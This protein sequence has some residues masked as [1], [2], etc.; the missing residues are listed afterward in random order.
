MASWRSVSSWAVRGVVSRAVLSEGWEIEFWPVMMVVLA[1][2]AEMW[3][4]K[5]VFMAGR[6]AVWWGTEQM[7]ERR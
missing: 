1:R 4:V 7:E 3:C 5:F 2:E 6:T